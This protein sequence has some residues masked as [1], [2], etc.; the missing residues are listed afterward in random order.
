[1]TQGRLIQST[2]KRK[3]MTQVQLGSKLGV[4]SAMISQWENDIRKP[5]TENV[6]RLA[7][8]L[9]CTVFELLPYDLRNSLKY[10]FKTGYIKKESRDNRDFTLDELLKSEDT[11]QYLRMLLSYENLNNVG[12]QMVIAYAEALAKTGNYTPA[13]DR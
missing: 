1:M 12:K 13:G 11:S 2:R 6:E 4:T 5:K 7:E 3:G 8:A 10:G 9:E